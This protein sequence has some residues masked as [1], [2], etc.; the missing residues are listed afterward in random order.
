MWM[1]VIMQ[2]VCWPGNNAPP[3][4]YDPPRCE[5]YQVKEVI[6]GYESAEACNGAKV[7][8]Q[9]MCLPEPKRKVSACTY[10]GDFPCERLD[11]K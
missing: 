9:W 1:L 6:R 10:G 3:G 8:M 7:G 5:H 2:T 11:G 4:V